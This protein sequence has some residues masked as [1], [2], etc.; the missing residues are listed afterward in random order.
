MTPKVIIAGKNMRELYNLSLIEGSYKN[1][2]CLPKL[3]SINYNDWHEKNGIDPDLSAP[4]ID[5]QD[6][7][8]NF[9][10]VGNYNLYNDFIEFLSDVSVH[11]FVFPELGYGCPLRLVKCNSI[12]SIQDLHLFGLS[13]C[14]DNPLINLPSYEP[15]YSDITPCYD[16]AI[17]GRDVAEYGIRVLQGTLD[18]IRK[19]PDVKENLK[20]NI[21]SV[22]GQSYDSA[23]V[24]YKSKSVDLNC[25]MRAKDVSEFWRNRNALLLDLIRPDARI[26]TVTAIGKDIPFYYKSCSPKSF[27]IDDGK[28]WFEFSLSVEFFNGVI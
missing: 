12:K 10:I 1:L 14:N 7:S 20:T 5:A 16:Y 24:V 17:D 2:A 25:L 26:L 3:K 27:Y 11:A 19:Q 4:T 8:L 22:S 21:Q 9:S 13:F 6:I 18:A 23:S 15:P 28:V